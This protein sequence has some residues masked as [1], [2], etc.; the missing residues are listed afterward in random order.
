MNA[1]IHPSTP[2][3]PL[4]PSIHETS[5][6][7]TVSVLLFVRWHQCVVQLSVVWP[8]RSL[9]FL[10]ILWKFRIPVI[11]SASIQDIKKSIHLNLHCS[12][13]CIQPW[14]T[15]ILV[16]CSTQID[17]RIEKRKKTLTLDINE[18]QLFLW[19][20]R[21]HLKQWNLFW[22]DVHSVNNAYSL[23]VTAEKKTMLHYFNFLKD[24]VTIECI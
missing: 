15:K 18:T 1:T 19:W 2:L 8:L 13:C 14:T 10:E 7:T 12:D 17:K 16:C 24:L 3:S 9:Q 4:H 11:S 22:E 23:C 6:P 20:F 21:P 5:A